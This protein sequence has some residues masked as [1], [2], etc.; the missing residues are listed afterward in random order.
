MPSWS[1]EASQSITSFGGINTEVDS[2]PQSTSRLLL[3]MMEASPVL[4]YVKQSVGV[5]CALRHL[6]CVLKVMQVFFFHFLE[7]ISSIV[8][9]TS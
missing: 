5:K 8:D 3:S 6:T 7:A 1:V 2:I 4:D 9:S